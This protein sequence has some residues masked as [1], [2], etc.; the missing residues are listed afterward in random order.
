[1]FGDPRFICVSLE[2]LRHW[3]QSTKKAFLKT[4]GIFQTSWKVP[5]WPKFPRQLGKSPNYLGAFSDYWISW[6][7]PKS[8]WNYPRCLVLVIW[9]I[10]NIFD[11]DPSDFHRNLGN[12][13]KFQTTMGNCQMHGHLGKFPNFPIFP[14]RWEITMELSQ[15]TQIS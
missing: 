15:I 10:S 5:K 4:S 1:M 7:V 14:G 6:K 3:Q 11:R 9:E 8:P 12:L 13:G 2:N